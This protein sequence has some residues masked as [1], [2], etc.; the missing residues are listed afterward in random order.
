MART[1]SYK[2]IQGLFCDSRL[3]LFS[4]PSAIKRP[5]IKAEVIVEMWLIAPSCMKG[6]PSACQNADAVVR[7]KNSLGDESISL[8]IH[9]RFIQTKLWLNFSRNC[10]SLQGLILAVTQNSYHN[11]AHKSITSPLL[12][13]VDKVLNLKIAMELQRLRYG[14][15][16]REGS[17]WNMAVQA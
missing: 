9:A 4:A 2:Q 7:T 11:R 12:L 13:S 8:K 6:E 3:L 10:V 5:W 15:N 16:R 14:D 17:T 1:D